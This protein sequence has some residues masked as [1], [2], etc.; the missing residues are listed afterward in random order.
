MLPFDSVRQ[1]VAMSLRRKTYVTALR[2]YLRLLEGQ[3]SVEGVELEVADI[4]L[5]Q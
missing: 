2:Q 5:L 1:A 4:P 3:A